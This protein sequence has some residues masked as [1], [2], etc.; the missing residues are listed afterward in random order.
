MK[1]FGGIR[2]D[3]RILD[4]F[5][6][7]CCFR[8]YFTFKNAFWDGNIYYEVSRLTL[9]SSLVR[10]V[11]QAYYSLRSHYRGSEVYCPCR[12]KPHTPLEFDS[13]TTENMTGL[14]V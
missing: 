1:V 11:I 9:G 6:I 12:D 7:M 13:V 4:N 3:E 14:R 8:R 5:E 10:Q 2:L